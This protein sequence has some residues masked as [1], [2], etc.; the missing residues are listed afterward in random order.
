[1]TLTVITPRDG[2]ALSLHAAKDYL[3]IGTDGE[4]AP[5]TRVLK[6]SW[7]AGRAM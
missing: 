3:R 2:E 4:D 1:M 5:V 7:R 6:Q